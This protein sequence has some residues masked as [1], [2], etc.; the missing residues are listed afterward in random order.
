M[1]ANIY[2]SRSTARVIVTLEF[3]PTHLYVGYGDRTDSYDVDALEFSDRLGDIPRL[4]YLPDGNV[5]NDG[6]RRD[7]QLFAEPAEKRRFA[8]AALP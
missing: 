4:I 1:K 7:R 5:R 6:E 3:S 2:N 8:S